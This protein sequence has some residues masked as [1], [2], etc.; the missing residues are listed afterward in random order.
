MLKYYNENIKKHKPKKKIEKKIEKK[1]IEKILIKYNNNNEIDNK[2]KKITIKE[3]EYYIDI[4]QNL[5]DIKKH[6]YIGY[7]DKNNDYFFIE[8]IN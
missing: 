4:N 8:D 1:K 3:I 5:I 7:I 6:K 2:L